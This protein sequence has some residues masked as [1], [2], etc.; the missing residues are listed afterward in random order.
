MHHNVLDHKYM[1]DSNS[2][3][4]KMK[5]MIILVVTRTAVIIVSK[6]VE[7]VVQHNI[8]N[9][10]VKLVA[11]NV[12]AKINPIIVVITMIIIIININIFIICFKTYNPCISNWK[13][14][15]LCLVL[16]EIMVVNDENI[17][18]SDR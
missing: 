3:N 17:F 10:I 5:Y 15:Q 9:Q 13:W 18:S 4:K 12:T 6:M 16:Q 7:V 14:Q 8:K 2:N 11:T 1:H